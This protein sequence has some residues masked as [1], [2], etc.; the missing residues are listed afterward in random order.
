[1]K[2]KINEI[3]K[4]DFNFIILNYL[5][6]EN[7]FKDKKPIVLLLINEYSIQARSAIYLSKK[8][9]IPTIGIQHGI[10][11]SSHI[12]YN[13][14]QDIKTLYNNS[15]SKIPYPDFFMV[16]GDFFKKILL[17]NSIFNEKSLLPFGYLPYDNILK[18]RDKND[19]K[20][21]KK[22]LNVPNNKR[23]ILYA[24]N[25]MPMFRKFLFINPLIKILDEN[26]EIFLIIK[27]HPNDP[28]NEDSIRTKIESKYHSRLLVV[29][30]SDIK[31]L[32]KISEITIT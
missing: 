14:N 9:K 3:F 28:I 32:I 24:D 1:M 6:L 29:K 17:K 15:F 27:Q 4:T 2:N 30:D 22:T 19:E 25:I 8:H 13:Q 21:L 20:K 31:N 11:Y 7:F 26:E 18:I 5:I 12:G 16:G 10:I 23:I